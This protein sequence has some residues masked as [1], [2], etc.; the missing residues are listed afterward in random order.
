MRDVRSRIIHCWAGGALTNVGAKFRKLL[1]EAAI[2]AKHDLSNERG[3]WSIVFIGPVL[4]ADLSAYSPPALNECTR[5]G[6]VEL[7]AKSN[8]REFVN[9]PTAP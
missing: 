6:H 5:A 9:A 3:V 1:S 4:V 7:S 2:S 8:A